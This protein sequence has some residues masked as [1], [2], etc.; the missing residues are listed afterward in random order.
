MKIF[1][2]QNEEIQESD[3]D[4]NLGVLVPSQMLKADA[5]PIDNVT[6]FAWNEEDFEDVMLYIVLRTPE[7]CTEQRIEEFK[8]KLSATDYVVIKIAE[9]AATA[10]EYAAVIADR[11]AW[12]KEINELEGS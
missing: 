3:C 4:L 5:A 1:N 11:E 9:G 2:I 12:R 10:E 8:S 6:K 7:D